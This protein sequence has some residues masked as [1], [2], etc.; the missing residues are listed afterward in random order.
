MALDAK[1]TRVLS[2][3][4]VVVVLGLLYSPT[5]GA[6]STIPKAVFEHDSSLYSQ[7]HTDVN[8]AAETLAGRDVKLNMSDNP[9]HNA[10]SDF[11]ETLP[12]YPDLDLRRL[13]CHSDT[14]VVG[15][16]MASQTGIISTGG[17]LYTDSLVNVEA[18]MKG[19]GLSAGDNIVVSRPGGERT[20]NGHSVIAEVGGFP[21]LK[22]GTRYLLFLQNLSEPK[23]YR[24]F[25]V[26]SFSLEPKPA[27]LYGDA[28]RIESAQS[29]NTFLTEVMAAV[30]A[31][32]A[33]IGGALDSGG[34]R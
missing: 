11:E 7:Y 26:G 3:L 19:S 15:R 29:E 1:L 28:L 22:V 9:H 10:V 25:N 34:S 4:T 12:K 8:I 14:I 18:V 5:C 2:Q 33:G 17:F 6:Q 20:V 24:T 23:S 30:T 21:M 27:D 31:P 16:V 32:C 13:A